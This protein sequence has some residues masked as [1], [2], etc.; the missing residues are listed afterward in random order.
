MATTHRR[1]AVAAR[2]GITR[3]AL[4]VA[5]AASVGEAVSAGTSVDV[6]V[7]VAVGNG[8]AVKRTWK[9]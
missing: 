4:A 7:M 6:V 1:G 3:V 9:C 5:V 2:P 8:V